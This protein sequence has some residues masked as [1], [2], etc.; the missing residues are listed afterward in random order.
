MKN[1]Q[2]IEIV[3]S[4]TVIPHTVLVIREDTYTLKFGNYQI[5]FGHH[6][7]KKLV[8]ILSEDLIKKQ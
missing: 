1:E 4:H 8:R 7:A 5:P 6:E 3:I 2:E